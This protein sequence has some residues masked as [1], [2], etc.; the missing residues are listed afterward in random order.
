[1]YPVMHNSFLI[2]Y[3]YVTL[4]AVVVFC[5]DLTCFRNKCIQN[6]TCST[7]ATIRLFIKIVNEL[8][9]VERAQIMS[10]AYQL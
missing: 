5:A 10:S 1:M 2:R 8:I 3:K 7:P 4:V 9:I 6:T